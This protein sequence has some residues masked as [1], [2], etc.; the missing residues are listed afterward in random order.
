MPQSSENERKPAS[1]EVFLN[2][3]SQI[4]SSIEVGH[5]LRVGINGIDAS[6]KTMLADELITPI[7]HLGRPVV[8]ASID[9]FHRPRV[10]RYKRGKD[11]PE[12]FYLDSFDNDALINHLLAPLGPDGTRQYKSSYFDLEADRPTHAPTLIAPDNA[13]LVVDGIFLFRPELANYWDLKV[14][15]Q[16]PFDESLSRAKARDAALLGSAKDVEERYQKRYIPGQQIYLTA[17][18]PEVQADI[19]INNTDYNNPS[20]V[21]NKLA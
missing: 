20:I 8:R 18:N 17:A 19:V 2:N 6:G 10:E 4:I 15:L 13:I 9:S 16:I 14:F 5:P 1:R 21:T 12:G 3:L 7:E 11:S